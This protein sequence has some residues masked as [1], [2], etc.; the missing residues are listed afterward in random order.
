MELLPKL[1]EKVDSNTGLYFGQSAH[2][3][4]GGVAAYWQK[5]E[6]QRELTEKEKRWIK[7]KGYD[8]YRGIS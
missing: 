5:I 2:Q 6:S 1:N 7:K 4:Q 8:Q 3:Y